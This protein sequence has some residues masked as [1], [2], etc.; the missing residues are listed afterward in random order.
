MT[1]DNSDQYKVLQRARAGTCIAFLCAFGKSEPQS[2]KDNSVQGRPD[3]KTY[4]VIA[5]NGNRTDDESKLYPSE[6]DLRDAAPVATYTGNLAGGVI[7]P[8]DDQTTNYIVISGKF[9]MTSSMQHSIPMKDSATTGEI[10]DYYYDGE[11]LIPIYAA[12]PLA[13]QICDWPTL[14]EKRDQIYSGGAFWHKTIHL[15][16]QT[17]GDGAYY[18]CK[19]YNNRYPG[20]KDVVRTQKNAESLYPYN[21]EW[22]SLEELEYNYSAHGEDDDKLFKLPVLQCTLKIGD[23]YCCEI[24]DEWGNPTY[25]WIAEDQLAANGMT[26]LNHI[27]LGPNPKIGDKFIGKEWSMCNTVTSDMNIDGKGIAIPI[28]VSDQ[29]NGKVEFTIDGPCNCVYNEITRR[30]PSFWRHTKWYDNS[31]QVLGHINQIMISDFKV[32]MYSDNASINNTTGDEDLVYKSDESQPEIVNVKDDIDFKITTNLTTQECTEKG[33]RNTIKMNTPMLGNEPLRTVTN[34]ITNNTGKPEEHYI[35]NYWREYTQPKILCETELV[36]DM[37]HDF[38]TH[39]KFKTLPG[40]EFY[41]QSITKDVRNAT[42]K[43]TLKEL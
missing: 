32:E 16:D 1:T 14:Y 37:G 36:E 8:T 9:V 31:K 39:Y 23:K 33:I 43:L 35:N 2:S 17:N 29:L 18:T 26:G 34:V 30:H 6:T 7:S 12:D 4:L 13:G 15:D 5:I 38:L 10:I 27:W 22:K 28:H 42:D 25:R 3:M 41:V 20:D 11:D 19:F 24:S 21:S 40:K